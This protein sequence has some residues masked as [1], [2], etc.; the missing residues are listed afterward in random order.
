VYSSEAAERLYRSDS[1]KRLAS[2]LPEIKLLL[3]GLRGATTV[4][5]RWRKLATTKIAQLESGIARA[6]A[7]EG[8]LRSIM[9]CRCVTIDQCAA[10]PT[11]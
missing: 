6:R 11:A 5:T 3:H 7:M 8:M 9:K 10:L 1:R 2:P 4:G